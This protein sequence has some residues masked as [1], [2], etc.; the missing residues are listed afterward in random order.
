MITDIVENT[1]SCLISIFAVL[2]IG[3]FLIVPLVLFTSIFCMARMSEFIKENI[4]TRHISLD[5]VNWP[6]M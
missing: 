6:K 3:P 1:L 2:G 5:N 4:E